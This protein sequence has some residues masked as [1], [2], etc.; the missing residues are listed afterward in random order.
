M[1]SLAAVAQDLYCPR[2]ARLSFRLKGMHPADTLATLRAQV[3]DTIR[4]TVFLSI[5]AIA[6]AIAAPAKNSR[7]KS[8]SRYAADKTI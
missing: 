4:G 7:A 2:D 1:A 6:S 8:D 3:I 5:G